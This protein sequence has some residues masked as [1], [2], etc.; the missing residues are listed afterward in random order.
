MNPTYTIKSP[1]H[2]FALHECAQ[3][4]LAWHSFSGTVSKNTVISLLNMKYH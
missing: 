1:Y 3:C 4:M 2:P